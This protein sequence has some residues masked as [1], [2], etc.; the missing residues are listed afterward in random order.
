MGRLPPLF[1]ARATEGPTFGDNGHDIWCTETE[2]TDLLIYSQMCFGWK[3][4]T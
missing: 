3:P 1:L 4:A 2:V